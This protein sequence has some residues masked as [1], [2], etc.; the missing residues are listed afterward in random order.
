MQPPLFYPFY[1]YKLRIFP[2]K[3]SIP[4]PS[5]A[6]ILVRRRHRPPTPTPCS[7]KLWHCSMLLRSVYHYPLHFHYTATPV[8]PLS[9]PFPLFN[10]T[11]V[12]RQISFVF[13][14]LQLAFLLFP[15]I[16]NSTM[17]NILLHSSR[18]LPFFINLI[19]LPSH[20]HCP[21]PTLK[22]RYK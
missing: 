22:Q 20:P 9:I 5:Y 1:P 21:V 19:L 13:L 17:H 11:F 12:L 8:I 2:C 18:M 16:T 10:I 14:S 15:I 4:P 3:F 6:Q 7:L